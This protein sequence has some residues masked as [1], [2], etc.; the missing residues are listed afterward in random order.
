MSKPTTLAGALVRLSANFEGLGDGIQQGLEGRCVWDESG[1]EV[2]VEFSQEV[3][4]GGYLVDK[5]Q[6]WIPRSLLDHIK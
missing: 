1:D 4:N 6:A 3:P 2:I 5:K